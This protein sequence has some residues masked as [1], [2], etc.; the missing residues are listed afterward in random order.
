MLRKFTPVDW[1]KISFDGG[2]WSGRQAVNRSCTIP[3]EYDQLAVT[4]RID[5]LKLQWK[6]GDP[7]KPHHYW[8]SDVAKWIEAS[9]YTLGTHPDPELENLVDRTIELIWSAQQGDGYLNSYFSTVEPGKRWTNVY[10]M[11]ELYCAGH[12]LEAAVAY[13]QALGKR[14]LLDIMIRYCDHIDSVFGPEAGKIHGY[15]GHE[16][17]ELALVKLYRVTGEGKYLR[18]A[19]YFLNERGNKPMFFEQEAIARGEDPAVSPMREIL[20]RD[21][22]AEG[23]YA[24]FQSHV[25]VRE[26]KEAVGHAVRAMYLYIA[27]ADAGMESGDESLVEAAKVLWRNVTR[28]RMSLTGGIGPLEFGERFTYDYDLPN[29]TAYNETC[30]SI[31]LVFWAHKMLQLDLDGEYGDLIEQTLYNGVL[32][33]ISL[34]GDTFFY[35]NHLEADPAVYEHRINRNVRMLPRRQSWF[36]VCCC[37]TNLAR[38]VASLGGYMYTGSAEGLQVHLYAGSK[39]ELEVRGTKT[40]ISQETDYP[41]NGLIKLTVS[42]AQPLHFALSFRV[43][44]WARDTDVRVNGT[45]VDLTGKLRNGYATVDRAWQANDT[46]N[47]DFHMQP[48]LVEAHP[49]VR[50]DCGKVALMR[51]PLV[52]CL[53]EADNGDRLW[54]LG[55]PLDAEFSSRFEPDLL[56]G[57]VSIEATALA[58]DDQEWKNALYRPA[59]SRY[60]ERKIKAVPYFVW[61]NRKPGQMLVWIRSIVKA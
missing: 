57:V 52:Y 33:G 51:G 29:D 25:P 53:E 11:H 55:L 36:E 47:I 15:P 5:V 48:R 59:G 24:L 8:D 43:P 23:P 40:L 9:A 44:S 16:V 31:G 17:L 39:A 37:P 32:S 1:K 10:V 56:G 19:E 34:K 7:K 3:A 60:V 4:G 35:A 6:P 20:N 50:F 21:Y 18:L 41:W 38:L 42:P 58:R 27:M 14:S 28:K 12:L 2:F 45:K 26:Q 22:L 49:A 54:D 46:V 30:A 61:S 13:Y